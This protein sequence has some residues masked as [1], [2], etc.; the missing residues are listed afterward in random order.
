VSISHLNIAVIDDDESMCRALTR[1]LH[2]AGFT[3]RTYFSAEAYLDDPDHTKTDFLVTDIQL[4]GM[5]GFDLKQRLDTGPHHPPVVFIT[6]HDEEKTREQAER[7]G[8]MAYFR[9]PFPGGELI[10]LIRK[11]LRPERPE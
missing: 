4:G 2:A 7:S 10:R 11:T 6:A 8:C 1:L 9:K 5:S 3:V